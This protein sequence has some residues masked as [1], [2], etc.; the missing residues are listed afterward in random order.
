MVRGYWGK[1]VDQIKN[2]ETKDVVREDSHNIQDLAKQTERAR[3]LTNSSQYKFI[4]KPEA[5]QL[6]LDCLSAG[7]KSHNRRTESRYTASLTTNFPSNIMNLKKHLRTTS[8]GN[9]TDFK[10]SSIDLMA[11]GTVS[12]FEPVKLSSTNIKLAE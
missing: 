12:R 2:Y 10:K 11:S 6:I 9:L 3:L 4:G 5:S 1:I 7:S 8:Y